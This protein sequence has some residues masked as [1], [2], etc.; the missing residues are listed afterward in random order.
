M[1]KERY[2]TTLVVCFESA[3]QIQFEEM[4]N[5]SCETELCYE[6]KKWHVLAFFQCLVKCICKKGM[7]LVGENWFFI[8]F[9]NA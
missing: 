4:G 7:N 8:D 9:F 6:R 3:F 2:Q 5:L 1:W